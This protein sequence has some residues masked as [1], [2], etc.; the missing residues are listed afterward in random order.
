MLNSSEYKPIPILTKNLSFQVGGGKGICAHAFKWESI[1][2]SIHYSLVRVWEKCPF[3]KTYNTY[4]KLQQISGV[5]S[6]QKIWLYSWKPYSAALLR[7]KVTTSDIRTIGLMLHLRWKGHSLSVR[8]S[9]THAR[10]LQKSRSG[11]S[12]IKAANWVV[13]SRERSIMHGK[14]GSTPFGGR[15]LPTH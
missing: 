9:R 5:R 3:L 11:R 7:G 8:G 15:V 4:I 6:I 13:L 10:M 1:S 12:A 2:Q 14:N